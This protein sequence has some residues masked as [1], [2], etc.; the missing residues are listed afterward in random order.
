M[1]DGA[2]GLEKL[3][4]E[5]AGPR[6]LRGDVAYVRE[7]G[8]RL[9]AGL[10]AAEEEVRAYARGLARVVWTLALTPGRDSVAEL[11][12]LFDEHGPFGRSGTDPRTVASLLAEAQRPADLA[13][14]LYDRPR[15]DGLDEIRACLFHELLLR[16]V[17]MDA[18]WPLRMWRAA[19]PEWH[20]LSWLPVD[21]RPFE[22]GAA[23]PRRSADGGRAG[24]ART[25][26]GA[27]GRVDPPVPRTAERPPLREI[28]T[29]EGHESI[30]S[31]PE[32][33]EFGDDPAVRVFMILV[34]SVVWPVVGREHAL[35]GGPMG[36][37]SDKQA[38]EYYELAWRQRK[39]AEEAFR[40]W[41]L[42]KHPEQHAAA[43]LHAQ[44]ATMYA[45]M[46][47][48]AKTVLDY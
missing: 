29:V 20:T 5:Q 27:E 4:R 13:E 14:L 33:G 24:G 36:R 46:A 25:G 21:L 2:S 37:M 32:T 45:G 10:A 39:S 1:N 17:D 41:A 30:L 34:R 43:M 9:S 18:L 47:A 40:E 35:R 7:L 6:A 48:A 22:A 42:D 38:T 26:L 16:G 19:R 8:G 31:A 15:R 3:A 44:M 11:V 23:F 12:R 28:T